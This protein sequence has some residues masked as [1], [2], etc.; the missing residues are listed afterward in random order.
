MKR[1][2]VLMLIVAAVIAAAP[3]Q[4]KEGLYLGANVVFNNFSGDLSSLDSGNGLGLRGGIGIGRYFALEAGLFRSDHDL[5]NGT[6]TADFKAGTI[7]A[8]LNFPLTGSHIEPYILGGVGTY[9]LDLPGQTQLDGKGGQLGI[10]I[11]I[12]L[13][14]ELNLN[15]GLERRNVTFDATATNPELKGKV[16][17]L[18]FGLTYHFI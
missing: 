3:A 14:P 7:D 6:G 12:Y 11:D 1:I 10:G 13:F 5:K 17:S 16:T 4:A 18:D 8:K 15:V 2:V 9:R